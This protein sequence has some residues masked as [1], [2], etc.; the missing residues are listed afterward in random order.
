MLWLIGYAYIGLL[1]ALTLMV[2]RRGEPM[3]R[4]AWI[5]VAD[6][7]LGYAYSFILGGG[8]DYSLF[9]ILVNSLACIFV[10]WEPA[11]RWQSLIG[12]SFIL[13]IGTDVGRVAS[14]VNSGPIDI[15]FVY[16]ATTGL[17]YIQLLLLM[18]WW[19]DERSGYSSRLG[20]DLPARQ[21]RGAGVA[22]WR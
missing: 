7:A 18:A 5:L 4:T 15:M 14:E 17:A 1:C 22:P 6:M 9:M 13:Q 8:W 10:L 2:N 11:G 3:R 19:I 21:T 16:W 12:W 20:T